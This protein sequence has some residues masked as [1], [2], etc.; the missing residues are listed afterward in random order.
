M[1]RCRRRFARFLKE[2][3]RQTAGMLARPVYIGRYLTRVPDGA[4]VFFPCRSGFLSCGLAGIV[5]VKWAT[6]NVDAASD[7]AN[8]SGLLDRMA[9]NF[10][11]M[12]DRDGALDPD[13]LGGKNT[14]QELLATARKLKSPGSFH[15]LFVDRA[16]F[17][18]VTRLWERL[19]GMVAAEEKQLT[20]HLGRLA[21]RDVEYV[22]VLIDSLKD[23]AWALK[24]ELCDN[25]ENVKRLMGPL[26]GVSFYRE[27]N[28]VLNSI[29]RLEVRGRDSAGVSVMFCFP[30]DEFRNFEATLA[31]FP[32]TSQGTLQDQYTR[33]RAGQVLLNHCIGVR[34]SS[35]TDADGQAAVTLTYKVAAE[36]GSLGDN[37]RFLRKEIEKD[38][39]LKV[40][41]RHGHRFHTI[42]SHTRWASVG[43]INE[44][45]CHPMD[46]RAKGAPTTSPIIHA[47]LNGDIDNYLMLRESLARTGVHIP[48]E[49]TTDTK[50]IPLQIEKYIRDG[51]EAPE[52]FRRAVNDF[53]GSH[54]ISMHTDLAPG[55]FFLAQRGSGQA[56]FIG[57]AESH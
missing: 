55:R 57:L 18:D 25:I 53:D 7:V 8:L 46:N 40:L 27:L 15:T 54:A 3:S 24:T 39:V 14:V 52:A 43:A 17:S 12:G 28:T 2:L 9:E 56:I 45:N 37:V 30:E 6:P 16:L 21:P 4:L 34:C 44:G 48:E 42:S 35:E 19:S 36:I 29:D 31:D 41:V 13:Y 38:E 5:A 23:T 32:T 33:R 20:E 22:T 1:A 50:I 51:E 26:D 10:R 49:I 11:V 47:C